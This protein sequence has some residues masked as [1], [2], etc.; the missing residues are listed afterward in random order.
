[1]VI[2][3]AFFAKF[4]ATTLK[5]WCSSKIREQRLMRAYTNAQAFAPARKNLCCSQTQRMNVRG[6]IKNFFAPCTSNPQGNALSPSLFEISYPFKIGGLLLVPQVLV[7]CFYDAFTASI[8]CTTKLVFQF[9]EQKVSYQ[10]K[11]GMRKDFK[12]TFSRSSH[13][14]L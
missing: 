13:F 8:L 12:S 9:W 7:Y 2:L 4:L 11:R 10:E 14:N 1:M 5:T 3:V 6:M